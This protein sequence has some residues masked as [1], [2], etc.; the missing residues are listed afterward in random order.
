MTTATATVVRH[1]L[2][3]AAR[4]LFRTRASEVVLAGSA[5]TGKS[6]ACLLRLHLAAFGI[7]GSGA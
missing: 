3:G 5:G 2:R 4:D 6:F 1:E 7:R